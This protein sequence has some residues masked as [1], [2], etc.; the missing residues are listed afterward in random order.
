MAIVG[1]MLPH[2]PP[3]VD[4]VNVVVAPIQR[5]GIGLDMVPA[6]GRGLTE[7]GLVWVADPQLLV[8]VYFMESKPAATPVTT[9]LATVALALLLDHA[10]APPPDVS[11][12][13][14]VL[15]T[16]TLVIPF[17][18]PALGNGRIVIALC[19]MAVPHIFD[20]EY[21][22]VSIPTAIPDTTLPATVALVLLA[23]H[24]PP[25]AVSESVIVDNKQTFVDPVIVPALG[26]GLT[27]TVVV[28]KDV[29]Q[30]LVNE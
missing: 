16:Q 11:A 18:V 22:T 12:N 23:D 29:P 27:V 2:T 24:V 19:A 10:P 25:V 4:S 20:T 14:I 6:I 9:P 26:N 21:N 8:T 7:I 5:L 17:M 30:L 13:V 28:A 3:V 15:P 1:V